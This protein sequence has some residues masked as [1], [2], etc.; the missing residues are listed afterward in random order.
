M[1]NAILG[2]DLNKKSFED[3][4]K[5]IRDARL[6]NSCFK[7]GHF[8]TGCMQK[9]GCYIEGCNGKHMIIIHPPERWLP[10]RQETREIHEMKN[11]EAN[12][13][14]SNQFHA[15][16]S[17]QHTRIMRLGPAFVI[18]VETPVLLVGKYASESFL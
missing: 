4:M 18:Q 13:T 1:C 15:R 3:R 12:P 6:C 17:A 5:V 8:A 9:S 14:C 16:E 11:N 2:N 7:V 10:A